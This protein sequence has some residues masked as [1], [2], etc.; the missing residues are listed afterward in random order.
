M[1]HPV[2]SKQ[3][4]NNHT[5]ILRQQAL[6]Y[7]NQTFDPTLWFN[8]PVRASCRMNVFRIKRYDRN[9]CVYYEWLICL[10]LFLIISE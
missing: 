1:M 3:N 7:L 9:T 4:E 8:D 10:F 5:D 6:H 2:H